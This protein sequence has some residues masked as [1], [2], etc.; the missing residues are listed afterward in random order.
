MEYGIEPPE[1]LID[2]MLLKGKVHQVFGAAGKGKSWMASW[3]VAQLVRNG[4][5]VILLDKENGQRIMVE[6]LGLLGAKED[7]LKQHLEY[8]PNPSSMPATKEAGRTFASLIKGHAPSL[9]IFDSWITFLANAGLDENVS[10]DIARWMEI[11]THSAREMGTAVLLLDHVPKDGSTARGSYRKMEEV[12]VQW[13]LK[14]SS[15]S[16]DKTAKLVLKKHKDRE[17]YLA[18]SVEFRV[19]GSGGNFI[20]ER[21]DSQATGLKNGKIKIVYNILVQNFGEGGAQAGEWRKASGVGEST[22]YDCINRLLKDGYVEKRPDSR[23][24][25]YY[26]K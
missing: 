9:I 13:E 16:R 20:F 18:D 21:L 8:Y 17:S 7:Q 4:E 22:F 1:M 11:Y 5:K 12:D 3:A 26:P 6:R 23:D 24:G 15:F 10:G 25:K 2:G 14:G 19:G